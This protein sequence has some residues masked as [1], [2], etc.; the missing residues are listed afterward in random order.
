MY[1]VG[2]Q[3]VKLKHI[4]I[5]SKGGNSFNPGSAWIL[6]LTYSLPHLTILFDDI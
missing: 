2:E 1:G 5:L 3:A 4:S 6:N